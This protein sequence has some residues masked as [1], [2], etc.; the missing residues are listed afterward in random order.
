MHALIQL[1]DTVISI[2]IFLLIGSAIMSWLLAFNVIDYR[3]QVVKQISD[4]LYRITEPPLRPIRRILP[5]L[6]GID[7]S[8]MVLILILIFVRNLIV[9]DLGMGMR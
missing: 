9:V 7:I 4:F 8:P 6:G 3:N 1:V 2:Y 5:N